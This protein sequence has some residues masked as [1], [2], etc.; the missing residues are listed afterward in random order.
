MLKLL[1]AGDEIRDE[2]YWKSKSDDDSDD[3]PTI[4]S[5]AAAMSILQNK[6][7]KLES[8]FHINSDMIPDPADLNKSFRNLMVLMI[9]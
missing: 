1:N 4:E 6:A 2:N 8:E 3:I 5:V 9:L 7:S